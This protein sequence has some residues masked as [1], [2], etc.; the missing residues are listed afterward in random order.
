M[1][2]SMSSHV[3][4]VWKKEAGNNLCILSMSSWQLGDISV[5]FLPLCSGVYCIV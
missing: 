5:F 3:Y 1:C 4:T 2:V